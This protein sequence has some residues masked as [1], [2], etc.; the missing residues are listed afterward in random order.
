MNTRVVLDASAAAHV[1]LRTDVAEALIEKLERS[2]LVISPELFHS[3]IANT[4]WK[5]V[6]AGELSTDEA[7][8]RYDES[9]SLVES[10]QADS[11]LITEALHSAAKH[12]HPVYDMLYAV[13]ARRHGCRVLTVDKKL[14][15]LLRHM[16]ID[17]A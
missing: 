13:L 8:E 4:L 9:I 15:A 1:V 3:E 7:L 2:N 12:R 6:S 10:F 16:D 17:T 5:Y 14:T 11:T